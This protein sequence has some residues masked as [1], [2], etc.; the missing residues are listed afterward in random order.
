MSTHKN[1]KTD[2]S[3]SGDVS[4][5]GIAGWFDNTDDAL[6]AV[7][8]KLTKKSLIEHC[9]WAANEYP[10]SNKRYFQSVK[11]F[12]ENLIGAG[13]DKFRLS[14][15]IW[16]NLADIAHD[17]APLSGKKVK[18]KNIL[19]DATA[20]ISPLKAAVLSQKTG[21]AAF[22]ILKDLL[23]ESLE[24][25]RISTAHLYEYDDKRTQKQRK[26]ANAAAELILAKVKNEN[27]Q[28][29][30][31]DKSVLA[32]YS[33]QGGALTGSDG[34]KGSQY[35]YYTPTPIA[36]GMWALLSELGFNGGKVLDPCGGTG[37][38]GATS[39]SNSVIDAVELS[40]T[41]GMVQKLVND[42]EFYSTTVAPFEKVAA[43]NPDEIYD[44]VVTNVPFGELSARGDN[45][46]HDPK[47]Q[48]ETLQGYFI[49]RSL[50][51]LKPRGLGAFIVPPSVV[52]GLDA[53]SVSV[54]QRASLMAEFIGAYRLPN[55]VFG[56]AAAD[57]MTDVIVFRKFSKESAE[58]IAEVREQN[59]QTL[60]DAN[61]QWSTFL[62]GQWFKGAGSRFILGEFVEKDPNAH[63]LSPEGRDRVT[64][65]ATMPELAKMLKKFPKSR[66]DWDMLNTTE[67]DPI[68]YQNGDTVIQSGQTLRYK[69]GTWEAL[70]H[71]E[72]SHFATLTMSKCD[73]PYAAFES[74]VAW[75]DVLSV[76]EFM[77]N[78][79][80]GLDIPAWVRGV[81]SQLKS[82]LDDGE[83][84]KYWQATVVAMSMQ[85]AIEKHVSTRG[86][87]YLEEY[88][89]LS[90]EMQVIAKL[91]S[92]PKSSLGSTV[93]DALRAVRNQYDLK[94]GFS[95]YWQGEVTKL[96]LKATDGDKSFEGMMYTA[97]SKWLSLDK[98]KTA[99]G[100]DFNEF[101][102]TD[103]CVSGDGKN[104]IKADDY[105]V[106]NLAG[107]LTKLDAD[108]EKA[109]GND[110]LIG[111]LSWQ[112]T[113]A[114]KRVDTIDVTQ[115]NFNLFS[116]Y[117]TVEEKLEF[118]KQFVH[119]D[120]MIIVN[121]KGQKVV[122]I[123]I[124][125]SKLSDQ[126]KINKRFGDYLVKRTLSTGGTK[127]DKLSDIEA[128]RELRK[129][130]VTANTQFDSWVKARP[131][132]Q[133]RLNQQSTDASK[134]QFRPVDDEAALVIAGMNPELKLHGYQCSFVR[135]MSREFK[136]INGFDVGLGKANPLDAKILTPNGWVLMGD[137]KVGDYVIGSN[138]KPTKVTGVYPQGE[139]EI[140]EVT[141]NDGAKSECCDEHLWAV[142]TQ[143]DRNYIGKVK[144][145]LIPFP[146][147][148]RMGYQ[149]KSL[150]E[151][152]QSLF[153]PH[154][155]TTNYSIPMVEPVE[156]SSR[157]ESLIHP[158]ALGVILGDGSITHK[159]TTLTICNDDLD[160]AEK[161]NGLLPDDVS[162]N[163]HSDKKSTGCTTY[164][165]S[166]LSNRTEN[167]VRQ[168]LNNYG[169]DGAS[170]LTKFIPTDY[171]LSSVDDRIELLRGLMDTD[172]YVSRDGITVQFSS[173]SK[174]LADGVVFIVQSLGG[175][176]TITEKLPSYVDIDGKR[177]YC[178]L[179][180]TVSLKLN[181]D[182]NPFYCQRKRDK[183]LPKTKYAPIR[184]IKKVKSIGNKLA[185]CIS[186][187]A[188]D[189]LYVTDDFVV[190]HNT[191]T[192][193]SAVQY[194]HNMG[195]KSKTLFVVPNSVLSN[196]KK[197]AGKAY[198]SMDDSLFIGLRAD[199]DGNES[200]K[201][202][203]YAV[204]LSRIMENN[205]RK[206]FMTYEAFQ[207][208]RLKV[209][210]VEGYYDYLRRND[211]S[212][213]MTGDKK[214]DEKVKYFLTQITT[215]LNDKKSNVPNLED[216]G[217]DSIVIDEAHLLK[218]AC[219]ATNTKEA[220]YLSMPKAAKRA[221]DAQAKLWVIR[222]KTPLNDGVLLLTAT[223]ITN[224]PL[225][226][227]SMLSLS[228]GQDKV[229][230]LMMGA[231][232][233]DSFLE[234]VCTREDEEDVSIDGI[235]R[236]ISVFK[237]LD[238]VAMLRN[239]IK[240]TCV[241]KTAKD[242]G[243]QIIVPEAE[244]AIQDLQ[245]GDDII[246]MLKEYKGAFR[247][248][249]DSLNTAKN[250]PS[251]NRGDEEAFA[252]VSAKF[253]LTVELMAHPFNLLKNMELLVM[254]RELDQRATFFSFP[255][256][257]LKLAN[258][259]IE[260]FNG[261]KIKSV[262]PR[263]NPFTRDSAV[264]DTIQ[265]ID[266]VTGTVKEWIELNVESYLNATN[267][268]IVIDTME[269]L[270]ITVFEDLAD[271]AG[272]TLNCTIPPKIAALLDNVTKEIMNPR[273]MVKDGDGVKKS[274]VVKQII[275]CDIL[276]THNK[277]RRLLMS[278]CGIAAS[279]IA[280]V[281]G[282]T[283]NEADDILEVQNGFNADGADNKY[284]IILANK[285]AEVGINLQIGT[286]AIHHLTIGWTP[287]SLQQRN[288]RGQRQGNRTAKVNI[289]F[290]D[291]DGTFDKQKRSMVER[292]G[293]WIGSLMSDQS[294]NKI[295]VQGG[296]SREQMET[297][298]E[299]VGD[300]DA[301]ERYQENLQA[302][303]AEARA[304]SNRERQ[305]INLTTIAKQAEWLKANPT[306][307][308]Y[309]QA[310]L[311]DLNNL[312]I[313]RDKIAKRESKTE[314]AKIKNASALAELDSTISTLKDKIL[315]SCELFKIDYNGE[316]DK[317]YPSGIGATEVVRNIKGW[318]YNTKGKTFLEMLKS[319]K[320][321]R[322]DITSGG[323][324]ES[325]W[326]DNKTIAEGMIESSVKAVETQA[327]DKGAF[328]A[329]IAR[330]IANGTG[331][332]LAGVPIVVGAF[333][334][335]DGDTEKDPDFGIVDVIS[336]N[337]ATAIFVTPKG[338][339]MATS[340]EF[341]I[342]AAD[343]GSVKVILPDDSGYTDMCK[344]AAKLED[345]SA[346]ATESGVMLYSDY[347]S[348]VSGYRTKAQK[349]V[350]LSKEYTLPPPYF[351]I[352]LND[353]LATTPLLKKI[354][355]EQ[356][357]VVKVI[358]ANSNHWDVKVVVDKSLAIEKSGVS[359]SS[360][361]GEE[362][363][364]PALMGYAKANG[365]TLGY[366][367]LSQIAPDIKGYTYSFFD[368]VMKRYFKSSPVIPALEEAVKSVDKMADIK[369]FV[370]DYLLK[371]LS[372]LSTE[373]A[374]KMVKSGN[375]VYNI[376]ENVSLALRDSTIDKLTPVFEKIL[377][378]AGF[379]AT[380]HEMIIQ[381]IKVTMTNKYY[382]N[383]TKEM[384]IQNKLAGNKNAADQIMKAAA[385]A[386]VL[387]NE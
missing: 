117:V 28:V 270:E 297:L 236:V 310:A 190:T 14:N 176:A 248:A 133:A 342:N 315:F 158:Y 205:H 25:E 48:K 329:S 244:T 233:A 159:S 333:V 209:E 134:L 65:N 353:A 361:I 91:A 30:D 115:M 164:G 185:Q 196:W 237:G 199:K 358:D 290:Y 53:K 216:L 213:Q 269:T 161:L 33:G 331:T 350:F 140:F 51:K 92:N 303:E 300:K 379:P 50:E 43:A 271:A 198:E 277:I 371:E 151:I 46:M 354:A 341:R 370:H 367:D 104:I 218:N 352:I 180:Y 219:T 11:G 263:M 357:K 383:S 207:M 356:R 376:I 202:S 184:Y 116:P 211:T 369:P 26:A 291:A 112:R 84:E 56:T 243:D 294:T 144:K 81:S 301:M 280:T 22:D 234:I 260:K 4:T 127:F 366:D 222:G 240:N 147:D 177:V 332:I 268:R 70:P 174:Q 203:E 229:N 138:G 245:L 220:K 121:D 278:K 304:K 200:V 317:N 254:D 106:G 192:A 179:H 41:S 283:N 362:H 253:D 344:R 160:I 67:T 171:L 284:Q 378:N 336:K 387:T 375:Y 246:D 355:K 100:A 31:A 155:G 113:E 239:S 120:A 364:V 275:F 95:K 73:T 327:A 157:G 57:T 178:A 249:I 132:I 345:T 162:L 201:S 335:L 1:H 32:K 346:Y 82:N 89:A 259:V 172:G 225:E 359:Y 18:K 189:H 94:T 212:I 165:I 7:S 152:R 10:D 318:S 58:K 54:R 365:L 63:H 323:P 349:F 312:M 61:V 141:F 385:N 265:K 128:L 226:V 123:E 373:L 29:T 167:S 148:G 381:A 23:I 170:S 99:L 266:E 302:K 285:K 308:A 5:H 101:E 186:V 231:A 314:T 197:E 338:N 257:Q 337:W 114:L 75:A 264:T 380:D 321:I 166:R 289:F 37:I 126:D 87:N 272:L 71:N 210:S 377:L 363:L 142:R 143:V 49:L 150:N 110:A 153:L 360:T 44:A 107:F 66:I 343:I 93:K 163:I 281:T 298:M 96:E 137:I 38:F 241:I 154:N 36:E 295:D 372:F 108:I 319:Y 119:P 276:A 279:K 326:Q 228:V 325:Q 224:S 334:A 348:E 74:K 339:G 105:F 9:Q 35:E 235:E 313:A 86:F 97:K 83:Q 42:N 250:D 227:Y 322:Y 103:Y 182:I 296:M 214:D 131:D 232:G 238:N 79:A 374:E 102:S 146:K 188:P 118:V 273:G 187:D 193:L 262:R 251:K 307:V 52:T 12:V 156:F 340:S 330:A 247:Y 292:K 8:A 16:L 181:G 175:N 64:S 351:S 125:G 194:A 40:E 242:V 72:D 17:Y 274:S 183:V 62:D 191:F 309:V 77:R 45:F 76:A 21:L 368:D 311:N 149:V 173:S 169:L 80:R 306:A 328:P 282:K 2:I 68:I 111:K 386:G 316:L 39:P 256:E 208:I 324:I 267:D 320:Y 204:D 347:S 206:I 299:S 287:D 109:Q 288:G 60:I 78:T 47:Y 98:A 27:Y 293:D 168:A 59:P 34:M 24:V 19:D 3:E 135:Q 217:I 124:N 221:I 139:K 195:V 130:A 129:M 90:T 305:L 6:D 15:G 122:D 255:A 145:G 55:E 382:S 230:N 69:N 136:G 13:V 215:V 261:K 20:T 88:P 252:K 286:Q 85:Q 223:P 258:Q 384:D